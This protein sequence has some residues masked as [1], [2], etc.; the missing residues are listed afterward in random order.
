MLNRTCVKEYEIPGT[1]K[2]IEKGVE[3]FIPV[4]GL[5]RDGKYYDEPDV[6]N[7]ERL[8]EETAAGKNLVNRPYLP[9]G[10]GPRNCIGMRLGKMQAKV[11][12]VLML[13][14]FKYELEDS[15]E[16]REMEFDPRHFLLQPRFDIYLHVTKRRKR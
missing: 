14:K 8:N 7:P 2:V 9:F 5:Q 11:G 15:L 13:Q 12:L 4:L 10:D 6:F 16:K 1:D 3:V